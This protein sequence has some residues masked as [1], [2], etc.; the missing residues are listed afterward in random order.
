MFECVWVFV[1][2]GKIVCMY[3]SDC[4]CQVI[5]MYMSKSVKKRVCVCVLRAVV[6]QIISRYAEIRLTLRQSI[7]QW[8]NN[9]NTH[10]CP[11][12]LD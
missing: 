7:G 1:S 10:F 4:L 12:S 8:G 2:V 5:R 6:N 9:F 11:F 3:V